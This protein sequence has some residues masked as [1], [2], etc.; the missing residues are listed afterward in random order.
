MSG[1]YYWVKTKEGVEIGYQRK[2]G[3]WE[4][5]GIDVLKDVNSMIIEVIGEVSEWCSN[6][7]RASN[8]I[9]PDVS[10]SLPDIDYIKAAMDKYI[11]KLP[12]KTAQKWA[13]IGF[14]A[15]LAVM[16]GNDC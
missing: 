5:H 15:A 10:N 6:E 11:E 12:S 9:I 8:C 13:N 14:K 2:S 4:L 3:Q 1:K 16:T 7:P